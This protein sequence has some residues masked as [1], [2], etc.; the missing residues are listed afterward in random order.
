MLAVEPGELEHRARLVG[1]DLWRLGLGEAHRRRGPGRDQDRGGAGD[2]ETEQPERDRTRQ[3]AGVARARHHLGRRRLAGGE[4]RRQRIAARQRRGDVDRRVRP[5]L[6][7]EPQAAQHHLFEL[8]V[9]ALHVRRHPRRIALV[10]PL[11][12][13]ARIVAARTGGG[14]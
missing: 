10:Q 11:E 6:R 7:L 2:E 14:R 9:E 3:R 4:R 13:L 5:A 12:H 8:R 1:E